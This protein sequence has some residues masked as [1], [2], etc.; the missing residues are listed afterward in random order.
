MGPEKSL[1]RH[2]PKCSKEKN[3]SWEQ[4]ASFAAAKCSK[5]IA[6]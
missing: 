6:K 2:Y 5:N 4:S 3:K 1:V